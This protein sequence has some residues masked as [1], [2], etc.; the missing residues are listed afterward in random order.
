M[1]DV[2][3]LTSLDR[4]VTPNLDAALVEAARLRRRQRDQ[5]LETSPSI[6]IAMLA[7]CRHSEKGAARAWLHR[8]RKAGRLVTISHDRRTLIPTFQLNHELDVRD[9]VARLVSQMVAAEMSPWA[10]WTW[11]A[12]PNSWLEA[13]PIEVLDQGDDDEVARAVDRLLEDSR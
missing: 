11:W 5:I 12:T 10:V 4:V 6:T 8:Q 7:E 1:A 13:V 9:D 3:G 2:L